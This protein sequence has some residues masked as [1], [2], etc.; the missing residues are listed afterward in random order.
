M[1]AGFTVRQTVILMSTINDYTESFVMEEQAV[2]PRPG[3][4]SAQYDL[5]ARKAALEGKGLPILL[6][7]GPIRFDRFDRRY[8]GG[9]DL[10]IR[11]ARP[12]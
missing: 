10:I 8:R 11:S 12:N 4:R 5:A 7:S 1:D 9:I 3:E 6:Q 2:F